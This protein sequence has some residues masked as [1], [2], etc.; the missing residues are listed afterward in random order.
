MVFMAF[1]IQKAPMQAKDSLN[2]E[3]IRRFKA[4]PVVFIGTVVVLVLVIVSFVLV[5]AFVPEA[6]PDGGADLT[7]GYYDKAPISWV[8]GNFFAQA[9]SRAAEDYRD[10]IAA[11]PYIDFGRQIWQRAFNAAAVHTAILQEAKNAGYS[12]PAKTVD[13]EVARFFQEN[14][15]FSAAKYQQLSNNEQLALWRKTQDDL[16]TVQFVS[17]VTSL[18]R[19]PAEA[20]FIGKMA[21]P[22]RSF[23]LA[24]FSVDAYPDSEYRSYAEEHPELFRTAHL[25]RIIINSSEREARQIRDAIQNGATTFEDAARTHSQDSSYAEKGGDMGIKLAHDLSA[26]I[27]EQADW[28]TILALG[29]GELSDVIKLNSGWA[30][31]RAEDAVQDADFSVEST[32]ANV[33]S[34]VRNNERGRMEDWAVAQ[35]EGFIALAKTAGFEDG[36]R[37]QGLET[38]SFGPLPINYG[39]IEL[40]TLLSSFSVTELASSS[41]NENFWRTAFSTPLRTPSEP[42]VQGNNVLVLYPTEESESGESDIAAIASTFSEGWASAAAERSIPVYF[43]NSGKLDDRFNETYNRYFTPSY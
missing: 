12:V 40:F 41:S 1:K 21:S 29:K 37:Q 33:R 7:F 32:L 42:L 24:A 31:F 18:F 22:R 2:S 30:F 3:I 14:G 39:D 13:R 26:E 15:R 17:D 35:A 20:A 10:L 9:Q 23:E 43:L 8:R 4:H 38:R 27:P 19:S 16:P 11:Y 5:P 25:S 28:E 36:A 6:G 34:Y